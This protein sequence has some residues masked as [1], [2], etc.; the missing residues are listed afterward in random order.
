MALHHLIAWQRHVAAWFIASFFDFGHL[1]YGQL[2]PV[3]IRYLPTSITWPYCGIKFRAYQG[4]MFFRSWPLTKCWF[5]IE[6]WE[7]VKLTCRKQGQVVRKLVNINLG[8][9]VNLMINFSC[10]Q[11]RFSLLL[12]C[13]FWDYSNSKQKAKQYTENSA[14]KLHVQY[15]NQNS[16]LSWVSFEQPGLGAPLLGL[17]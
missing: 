13:V 5:L 2:T 9:T 15:S 6:S 1:Y 4:H 14:A 17:A 7:H 11:N 10:I 8:L 3:K 12:F 16:H